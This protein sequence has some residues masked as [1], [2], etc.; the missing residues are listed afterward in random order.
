[1]E[2]IL[3]ETKAVAANAGVNPRGAYAVDTEYSV[4]DLVEFYGSEY[5]ATADTTGAEP[6][7]DPWELFVAAGEDGPVTQ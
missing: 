7:A 4:N 6:P 1:M 2:E 3:E 5:R